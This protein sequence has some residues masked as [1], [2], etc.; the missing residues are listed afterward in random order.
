MILVPM[1]VTSN[2]ASGMIKKKEKEKK[3]ERER[4]LPDCR[5][6]VKESESQ[7]DSS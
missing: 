6:S 5:A 4:L 1:I 3:D 2:S 7:D